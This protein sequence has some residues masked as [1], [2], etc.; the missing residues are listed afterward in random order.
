LSITACWGENESVTS[1]YRV[2]LSHRNIR[3]Y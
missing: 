1:A 2:Q 3:K